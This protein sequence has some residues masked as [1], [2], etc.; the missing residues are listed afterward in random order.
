MGSVVRDKGSMV[1]KFTMVGKCCTHY[2]V[3]TTLARDFNNDTLTNGIPS[4]P[5]SF[6]EVEANIINEDKLV[7]NCSHL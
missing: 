5:L 7:L 1:M 3:P 2:D 6:C 4:P